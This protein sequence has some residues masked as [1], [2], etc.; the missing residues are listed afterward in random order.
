MTPEPE[1]WLTIRKVVVVIVVL[2]VIYVTIWTLYFL[3]FFPEAHKK[4]DKEFKT[5][6]RAGEAS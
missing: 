6:N 2:L 4:Y 3:G 5:D 1:E